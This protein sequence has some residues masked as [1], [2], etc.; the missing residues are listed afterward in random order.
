MLRPTDNVVGAFFFGTPCTSATLTL[1]LCLSCFFTTIFPDSPCEPIPRTESGFY[2]S[3]EDGSSI[4]AARLMWKQHRPTW[5]TQKV[6]RYIIN[7]R[8]LLKPAKVTCQSIKNIIPLCNEYSM[9]VL[10]SAIKLNSNIT[11]K[12]MHNFLRFPSFLFFTF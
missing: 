11:M 9:R 5:W 8:P 2:W 3:R 1:H 6:R 12:F 7:R 10:I 4:D